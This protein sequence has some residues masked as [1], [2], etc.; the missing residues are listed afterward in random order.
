MVEFTHVLCPIDFSDTSVRALT[1]AAAFACWYDAHLEILHATPAVDGDGDTST[2]GEPDGPA[3]A[4]TRDIL[5]ARAREAFATIGATGREPDV[6]IRPGPAHEVIA[7]RARDARADLLV[8]GTHGRGGFNRLL[9]GS[10]A[11]KVLRQV[12]CPILTVPPAAPAATTAA[13]TFKRI[14][15]ALDYSPASLRALR[16]ALELGR[17]ANGRVTVVSALEYMDPDEPCEHVDFDIRQRREHFLNHARARLHEQLGGES[18]TWCE[19]EEV[20][21]VDRAYRAV[22]KQAAT[23]RADLIV[24]GAQGMNGLALMLYGSNTQHVVRS[25]VCPVLTVRA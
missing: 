12:S 14:V 23:A 21:V 10:V 17:Q 22:L 1:Y 20:V 5:T 2:E 13:A 4:G 9:L 19:I 15:C 6:V 25:S 11:E 18:T 3:D 16:Y 24:M 7:R 8:I